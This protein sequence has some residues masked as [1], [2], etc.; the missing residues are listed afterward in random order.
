M[1]MK[2]AGQ[3]Q[4]AQRMEAVAGLWCRTASTDSTGKSCGES[5][6][7]TAVR[8]LQAFLVR[9]QGRCSV[10]LCCKDLMH[11]VLEGCSEVFTRTHFDAEFRNPSSVGWHAA[12]ISSCLAP[13]LPFGRRQRKLTVLQVPQSSVHKLYKCLHASG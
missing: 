13:L 3:S 12:T 8:A 11:V 9:H 2:Q 7:A 5:C 10:V 4:R 1:Q 6:G